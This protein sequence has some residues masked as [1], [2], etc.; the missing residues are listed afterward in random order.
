M[1]GVD[2]RA[3]AVALGLVVAR[4]P[5][6]LGFGHECTFPQNLH[7][8]PRGVSNEHADTEREGAGLTSACVPTIN[9]SRSVSALEGR[10]TTSRES[11]PLA[12]RPAPS[13]PSN[14]PSNNNAAADDN[15]RRSKLA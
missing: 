13:R 2:P 8:A 4:P 6:E 7:L 1:K 11:S 15:E 12:T 3:I 9:S 5:E 14:A 10:D